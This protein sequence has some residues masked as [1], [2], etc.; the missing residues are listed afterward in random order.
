M[1]V[2]RDQVFKLGTEFLGEIPFADLR[3][4]MTIN[5]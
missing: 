4:S 2:T 1:H 3:V 5:L